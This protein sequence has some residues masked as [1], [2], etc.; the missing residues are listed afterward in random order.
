[1]ARIGID[2]RMY[3]SKFTGIGKY[4][5]E[6][7]SE[8]SKQDKKN[9][10]FLIFNEEEFNNFKPPAKNIHKI[11]VN[12]PIY[13]LKEQLKLA[14]VLYQLKLDLVHFTHFNAPALYFKKNILTIHDLTQKFYKSETPLFKYVLYKIVLF[15][16]TLKASK[17]ITV[18]N[19][20]KDTLSTDYPLCKN[21]IKT[22]HLGIDPNSHNHQS[23]DKLNLPSNYILYTG[24]RKKHKN[25]QNLFQAFLILQSDYKYKGKL[26]ITGASDET[27]TDPSIIQI[28]FIKDENLPELYRRSSCYVFPSFI[29]GFGLPI[30]ECFATNTPIVISRSGSLPEIAGDAALKFDPN[31]PQ[32]IAHK[33]N[34]ILTDQSKR[35]KLIEA[36][37]NRLSQFSLSKMGNE[38]LNIYKLCLKNFKI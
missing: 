26:I 6:L 30:L 16:N 29:E 12:C 17:I 24:N 10:Y 21:K 28:G 11:E 9:E 31:D 13:S 5:Q 19:F 34:I 27:I 4:T 14:A 25:L 15:I 18:S 8:I 3:S 20:T 37:I 33:I 36:G 2:C 23:S 22:I 38:T 1:M 32:D 35:Q 7:V